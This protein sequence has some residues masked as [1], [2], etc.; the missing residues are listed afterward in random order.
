M[1]SFD[2]AKTIALAAG[3]LGLGYVGWKAYSKVSAAGGGLVDAVT[4]LPGEAVRAA[5]ETFGNTITGIGE[6]VGIPRTNQTQCERDIA[7]GRTWDASFSCPAG[8][9]IGS[10]F[11][12]KPTNTDTGTGYDSTGQRAGVRYDSAGN[13]IGVY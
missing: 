10:L 3:L 6:V 11:G 4:S 8:T 5:D 13:V 1:I 12:S 2:N 7:A 9:F